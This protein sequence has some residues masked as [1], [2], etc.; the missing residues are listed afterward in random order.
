MKVTELTYYRLLVTPE[1]RVRSV[2]NRLHI[3][4]VQSVRLLVSPVARLNL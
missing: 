2:A 4:Y 3:I 1:L